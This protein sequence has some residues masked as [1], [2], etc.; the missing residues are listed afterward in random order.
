MTYRE[1]TPEE[2]DALQRFAN[3]EHGR[4]EG[5]YGRANWKEVL[6]NLYWYNARMWKGELGD[7]QGVGSILHGIRNDFGPT[8]L[9]DVCDVKPA[10]G[11]HK[12]RY[13][14]GLAQARARRA[15]EPAPFFDV[16]AYFGA[17]SHASS[18]FEGDEAAAR[19]RFEERKAQERYTRVVLSRNNVPM[20]EWTRPAKEPAGVIDMTLSWAVT[21]ETCIALLD[22]G[23]PE[24]KDLAKEELRK[25]GR[26]ADKLQ[27]DARPRRITHEEAFAI[28]QGRQHPR[29]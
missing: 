23:S 5:Q 6:G 17:G 28:Q 29:S 20:N 9:F 3:Y 4:P 15:A 26:L 10:P 16:V 12:L 21:V 1:L 14:Q 8:W 13:A 2:R 24:G 22:G 18:R 25:L 7:D 11:S 19:T 27:A